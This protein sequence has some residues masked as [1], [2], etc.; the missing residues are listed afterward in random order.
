[1]NK[2]GGD[3]FEL[4]CDKSGRLDRQFNE[5]HL[6]EIYHQG[7]GLRGNPAALFFFLESALHGL[8]I[9]SAYKR[10]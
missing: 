1:M 10:L 3:D 4:H 5:I 7:L 2:K 9:V 6:K 8:N